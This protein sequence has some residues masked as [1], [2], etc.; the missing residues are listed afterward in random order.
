M[1]ETRVKFRVYSG[2]RFTE[3][4]GFVDTGATL[5]KIPR[6]AASRIDRAFKPNTRLRSC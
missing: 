4:D 6:S 1:G 2:E 5:T 3:L